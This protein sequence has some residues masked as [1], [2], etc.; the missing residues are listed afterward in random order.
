M[1]EGAASGM[2]GVA[3]RMRL[4]VASSEGVED[5]WDSGPIRVDARLR[6]VDVVIPPSAAVILDVEP[7]AIDV[8]GIAA[9]WV[10]PVL[11]GL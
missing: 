7:L 2:D 5:V 1:I 11:T 9:Q 3:A 6:D 4:R 8:Q 10:D